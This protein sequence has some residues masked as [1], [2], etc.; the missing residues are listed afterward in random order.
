[1][2][3]QFK[4]SKIKPLTNTRRSVSVA[5]Q[6]R[7]GNNAIKP[8]NSLLGNSKSQIPIHIFNSPK[9]EN[10]PKNVKILRKNVP[11]ILP[12]SL[13]LKLEKNENEIVVG[14]Y[15]NVN[16]RGKGLVRY[17]GETNFRD[18][19]WFGIELD[20]PKGKNNGSVLDR[21]YFVCNDNH[22]LFTSLSN[23]KKVNYIPLNNVNN[24]I[25]Q[26]TN[27]N[28]LSDSPHC[29]SDFKNSDEIVLNC[30]YSKLNIPK[31]RDSLISYSSTLDRNKQPIFP[32][33]HLKINKTKPQ[34]DLLAKI[35]QMTLMLKEKDSMVE[36]LNAKIEVDKCTISNMTKD[37]N[38]LKSELDIFKK[39][40]EVI[41]F[42][43]EEQQV[44][45]TSQLDRTNTKSNELQSQLDE[46]R[47]RAMYLEHVIEEQRFRIDELNI[48]TNPITNEDPNYV[49][50]ETIENQQVFM[51]SVSYKPNYKKTSEGNNNSILNFYTNE[52]LQKETEQKSCCMNKFVDK[53]SNTQDDDIFKEN[54]PSIEECENVEDSLNKHHSPN[55][56][57][58]KIIDKKI[59]EKL[60]NVIE[61]LQN[62]NS[63]CT[64]EKH[65][66]TIYCDICEVYGLHTTQD[67][68]D[69]TTF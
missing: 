42:Q 32:L 52:S 19:V 47:K 67:C 35:N 14:D 9:T 55:T 17:I 61:T 57:H 10:E 46:A 6:P 18:G 25:F 37:T 4:E 12:S 65:N 26:N 33:S 58:S 27:Q 16:E 63:V 56:S 31:C 62:L 28:E 40:F 64:K 44:Q 54:F 21:T 48:S 69:T 36:Y 51:T 50:D 23:L 53:E 38:S 13:N 30:D 11:E 29:S 49:Y 2:S 3:F 15:V 68:C 41:S 59:S 45:F 1:M 34:D 66:K 43:F 8:Y 7:K 39:N 22:G 60:E 5:S 24:N 20:E